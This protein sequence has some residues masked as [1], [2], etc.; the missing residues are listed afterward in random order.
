MT[1]RAILG[2]LDGAQMFRKTKMTC[3][4][5]QGS[6][7]WPK[8]LTPVQGPSDLVRG[9]P[10]QTIPRTRKITKRM[11]TFL[12]R[13]HREWSSNS[14]LLLARQPKITQNSYIPVFHFYV[15]VMRLIEKNR[16]LTCVTSRISVYCSGLLSA[17]F[18]WLLPLNRN[19]PSLS[20]W[21]HSRG[22]K[23]WRINSTRHTY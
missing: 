16:K 6:R 5:Y 17:N 12:L 7:G 18:P 4:G 15:L 8:T 22:N 19:R 1:I 10:W 3:L 14:K 2:Y 9:Q 21:R 23:K 11:E 20:A 13:L